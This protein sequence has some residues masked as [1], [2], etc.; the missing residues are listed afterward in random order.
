[1]EG[2]AS[3]SF[4][5]VGQ[6]YAED[7]AVVAFQNRALERLRALPG[8][9]G[10]AL[11]DQIP[12]GANYDCRGFHAK[13]RM[14]PSTSDDPCIQRYGVTD[15]YFSVMRIPIVAG[16]TFDHTDTA[17]SQPV[18]LVSESTARLVW[19]G[20]NPIGAQVSIGNARGPWRTVVGIVGDVHHADLT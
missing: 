19:G 18:I 4:S 17:T 9:R 1:P 2:V 20:G 10:V 5:L 7:P 11:A 8:V 6:A 15:G 16:R 12:F 3:L 13:G 14:K